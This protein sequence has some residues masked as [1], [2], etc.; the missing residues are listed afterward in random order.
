MK[1]TYS[2]NGSSGAGTAPKLTPSQSILLPKELNLLGRNDA[3]N[4]KQGNFDS[5][6]MDVG[7][8]FLAV[9]SPTQC[10]AKY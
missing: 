10:Y 9:M 7:N 1:L 2:N 3:N 5:Q 6:T 8:L 4:P